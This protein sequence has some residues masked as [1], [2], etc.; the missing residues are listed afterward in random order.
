MKANKWDYNKHA[1]DLVEIPD[2][3]ATYADDMDQ[4]VTCPQCGKKI[5]FGD[6]YTSHEIHTA[7]GMG[8][9]VC[10]DCYCKETK[11]MLEAE[12]TLEDA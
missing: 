3:C 4:T 7:H 9:A 6:G 8:F 12:R 10:E 5:K 2:D 1:Y 11:R